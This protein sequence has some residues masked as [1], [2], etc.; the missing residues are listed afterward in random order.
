MK[1][2]TFT[3]PAPVP[4]TMATVSQS[5]LRSATARSKATQNHRLNISAI[6][7]IRKARP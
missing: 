3:K 5:L 6:V 2:V 7:S 4:A 1:V